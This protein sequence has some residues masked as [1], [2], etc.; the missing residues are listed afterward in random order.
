MARGL[1]HIVHVVTDL[2]VA[3]EAYGGLGFTV[4]ARNRHPWG[5]HNRI[6][7]F[8]GFFIELLEVAEPAAIVPHGAGLFS[9]GAFNRD[10][11]TG[12]GPGL[13][14]L[15]LEGKDPEADKAAFDAAGYGGFE[16]FDFARTGR[17]PDGSAVEVAFS[18]AFARDPGSPHAGFFTCMQK[19]P[20]NFWAPDLQHH[21]NGAAGIAGAVLTADEPQAHIA[22]LEAFSGAAFER[23]A[24]SWHRGQTPRGSIDVM[25]GDVFAQ[26]F[27]AVPV[28]DAGLRLG[29]IRFAVKDVG[30]TGRCLD[31]S[32]VAASEIEGA[33][34]IGPGAAMGAS[35][36]F[37][38]AG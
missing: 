10:F 30:I 19:R 28:A 6:I 21:A 12:A 33:V 26:H 2:D 11:I 31:A 32:G 3:G 27:G 25:S 36:V 1:D 35:L 7:Q 16:L 18:L 23:A 20:E 37:V 8:P 15:V 29:A 14:M 34:V 13:S 9:F 22:F 5:T 38:P 4:G 24:P 17:R